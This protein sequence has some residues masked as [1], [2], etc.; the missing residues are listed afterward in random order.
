MNQ[1]ANYLQKSINIKKETPV[2]KGVFVKT[3]EEKELL[4]KI[5]PINNKRF[6]GKILKAFEVKG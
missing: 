4:K 5:K 3:P 6:E 1:S 2:N